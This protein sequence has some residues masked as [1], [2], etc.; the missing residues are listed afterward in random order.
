VEPTGSSD[1]AGALEAAAA[2]ALAEALA[3]ARAS[4]PPSLC[5]SALAWP[6]IATSATKAMT[7]LLLQVRNDPPAMIGSPA[8][9]RSTM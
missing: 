4:E 6:T 9:A 2:D 7:A 5:R 8:V 1:G 3:E